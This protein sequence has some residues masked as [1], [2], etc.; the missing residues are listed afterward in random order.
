MVLPSQAYAT[1]ASRGLAIMFR[2]FG[3]I[4]P[5]DLRAPDEGYYRKVPCA[6]N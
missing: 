1:L 2:P 4:P 5:A 6:P 3:F